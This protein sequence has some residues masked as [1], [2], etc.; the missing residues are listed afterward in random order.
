MDKFL[1]GFQKGK[2]YRMLIAS[3]ALALTLFNPRVL[4]AQV[5]GI[6]GFNSLP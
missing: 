5:F 3:L 6:T 2:S 4:V 1:R